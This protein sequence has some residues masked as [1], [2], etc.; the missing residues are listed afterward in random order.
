MKEKR[1]LAFMCL[2]SV[3]LFSLLLP[4]KAA[5]LSVSSSGA[6]MM[7]QKS[8]RILFEKNPHEIRRIASITKIMTAII[9]IESGELK[10]TVKVSKEAVYTEGSSIYL[11]PGEL[12]KLEDLVYG[13]MLRSGNDA[14]RAIAEHVGGSLEGFVF[15]MNKKAEEIGMSNTIFSNPHGLDDHEEHYSTPYDMALLTRYAMENEEYQKISGTKVHKFQRENGPQQW[16]NKNRL[17]TE[18][19]PHCTGGKTG[20]TKRAGRTLITTAAKNDTELI[21]VT[22]NGPDDWSDHISLYEYAFQNYQMERV[23][24]KGP[25][26]TGIK[27]LKNKELFVKRN[28]HFPLLETEM[29]DIKI[30]Y[31]MIPHK[32]L[33]KQAS[34]KV[35]LAIVK[36][37][38]EPMKEIPIF[39]REIEKKED[40][41]SWWEKMKKFFF[42]GVSV[43]IN[44]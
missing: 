11:T 39:I 34:G 17:L 36:F 21:V 19:Y 14:A 37:Q 35:G 6:I 9:A 28:V 20:F 15:L 4:I 40:E 24:D 44:D 5:A 30:E 7:E 3:L 38:N 16:T 26:E 29:R 27:G 12:I 31:K 32:Q 33:M 22:L 25:L 1:K 2:I 8:G 43:I 23:V 13:L 42:G 18:L 10:E 41:K